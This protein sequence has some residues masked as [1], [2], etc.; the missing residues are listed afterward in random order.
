MFEVHV[1]NDMLHNVEGMLCSISFQVPKHNRNSYDE[2]E[3]M[4]NGKERLKYLDVIRFLAVCLIVMSHFNMSLLA[5]GIN[6]QGHPYLIKSEYANGSF[7]TLGVSLFFI[8]SGVSLYYNYG[9]TIKLKQYFKKRFFGIYPTFWCSYAL[10]FIYLFIRRKQFWFESTEAVPTWKFLLSVLGMDGYFGYLGKNYYLIGEWFL[11]CI[12]LFYLAFPLLRI[13]VKKQPV[14]TAV[15]GLILYVLVA[16]F[17]PFQVGLTR[18]LIIRGCD[19]LFGMLWARWMQSRKTDKKLFL[20]CLAVLIAC[21]VI[22]NFKYPIMDITLFG[23]ALFVCLVFLFERIDLSHIELIK[24]IGK[25]SYEIFLLH[26]V[27]TNLYLAGFKK[28]NYSLYEG[29]VLFA[30]LILIICIAIAFEKVVE[31]EAGKIIK[32]FLP[33]KKDDVSG[34]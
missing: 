30:G 22:D 25:Y 16:V 20:L 27:C 1:R 21:G 29:I 4:T 17:N 6:I 15:I 8:I 31:R 18:N 12:I 7:G 2:D 3:K 13:G 26:H 14:L 24:V 9:E 34:T 23:W 33:P 10:V 32:G 28:H 5:A 19:F 11:G